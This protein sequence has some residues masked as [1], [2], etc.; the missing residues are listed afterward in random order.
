[1]KLRPCSLSSVFL[2]KRSHLDRLR[3]SPAE[4]G[5]PIRN[6]RSRARDARTGGIQ[7][8]FTQSQLRINTCRCSPSG[9]NN[10]V[11][12]SIPDPSSMATVAPPQRPSSRDAVLHLI[13]EL[14]LNGEQQFGLPTPPTGHELMEMWPTPAPQIPHSPG[15][16]FFHAQERAFFS[17]A[18][19]FLQVQIDIDL[20]QTNQTLGRG[21]ARPDLPQLSAIPRQQTPQPPSQQPSPSSSSWNISPPSHH[22]SP[23]E[24]R[25]AQLPPQ[26]TKPHRSQTIPINPLPVVTGPPNGHH[27]AQYQ[28]P[29]HHS[30]YPY[31]PPELRHKSPTTVDDDAWRCS[32]P[33]SERRR[34]G[35]G[36]RKGN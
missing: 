4:P 6:P 3:F 5:G 12:P 7:F 34:A 26:Q 23:S 15:S 27:M 24:R 36:P 9:K 28:V 19:S 1:M 32:M 10:S 31:P 16:S 29:G 18:N 11:P 25:R 8:K 17:R 20:P 2:Y 22:Q 14:N 13:R 21:E 35:K 33:H 30:Q